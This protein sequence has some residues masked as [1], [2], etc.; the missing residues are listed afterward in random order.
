[1]LW[2]SECFNKSK[3]LLINSLFLI[4]SLCQV[5]YDPLGIVEPLCFFKVHHQQN[6]SQAA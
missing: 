1:M 6:I 5:D 2:E 4:A 3:T